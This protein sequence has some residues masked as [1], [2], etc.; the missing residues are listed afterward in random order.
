[1]LRSI[2]N[3]IIVALL[4]GIGIISNAQTIHNLTP[5]PY[6][7]I[8]KDGVYCFDG[9]PRVKYVSVAEGR[10]PVESYRLK[11]DKNG[12]TIT[13][14]D[15]AGAFY[16]QQTLSQLIEDSTLPYCEIYDFPRFPYRGVHFD[17]SR[18][19]RSIDF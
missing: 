18:H 1:M 3:I 16:A 2:I 7:I 10:M 9:E 6:E 19:F 13:S 4:S 5:V 15:P 11:I 14:A 17:V 12:A 8:Q